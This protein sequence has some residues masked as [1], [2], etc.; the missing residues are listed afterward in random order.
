[1]RQQGSAS[2]D[3]GGSS[4]PRVD[5]A[6][7]PQ[8]VLGL[9]KNV[10]Q[11]ETCTPR[12]LKR[13]PQRLVVLYEFDDGESRTRVVGKWFSTDRGAVVA[14]ELASLHESGFV[15]PELAVPALVAYVAEV[16][17]LFVEAIE[18]PLLRELLR[19]RPSASARAGAWLAA[20][21]ASTLVIPRSCGPAKQVHAVARWTAE[22][23]QL[24]ELGTELQAALLSLPDPGRPVH[25]DYYHSQ[26]AIPAR[27]PTTVFDLDEAGMGNPFFDVAHFDAHLDLLAL[28][29]FGD[30]AAFSAARKTF[31]SAYEHT[32]PLP[33]RRPALQ[34]FAWF[35]LAYQGLQRKADEQ[36]RA[37][38]ISEVR[39]HLSDA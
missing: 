16:R 14:D 22:E 12:V 23:P 39:R 13:R 6:L 7:D 25:Y 31:H 33:S 29:W 10:V 34:A 3:S 21:H 17:A 11:A 20:F 37:Y 28:Q 38:S 1:M 5:L 18:G 15:G 30:P 32:A 26:V 2:L 36:E 27:G 35:K 24:S 8:A 9:L 4:E 19:T